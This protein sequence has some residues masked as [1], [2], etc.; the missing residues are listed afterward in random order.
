MW[1]YWTLQWHET[2]YKIWESTWSSSTGVQYK[3]SWLQLWSCSNDNPNPPKSLATYFSPPCFLSPWCPVA[4]HAKLLRIRWRNTTVSRIYRC[5]IWRMRSICHWTLC[6]EQYGPLR[7][8]F[9]LRHLVVVV[10]YHR[11][12]PV[13]VA[14]RYK[15]FT[16]CPCTRLL[17]ALVPR[18]QKA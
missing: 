12:D 17:P 8:K 4:A 5:P 7:R 1:K 11:C 10:R 15:Y 13:G 14:S 9:A 2:T 6:L 3:L 16:A 18:R